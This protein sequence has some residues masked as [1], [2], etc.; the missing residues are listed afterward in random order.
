VRDLFFPVEEFEKRCLK[1]IEDMNEIN[2]ETECVRENLQLF[3]KQRRKII[4]GKTLLPI[5]VT[6]RTQPMAIPRIRRYYSELQSIPDVRLFTTN[7]FVEHL[8]IQ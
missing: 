3:D 7:E 2:I 4:Q 5:M 8:K 1:N 6:S